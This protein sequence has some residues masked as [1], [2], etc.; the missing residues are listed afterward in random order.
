MEVNVDDAESRLSSLIVQVE[1]T[2]EEIVIH[3]DNVPVAKLVPRRAVMPQRRLG[4]WAKVIVS[5]DVG[6]LPQDLAGAFAGDQ[7]SSAPRP[8][9]DPTVVLIERGDEDHFSTGEAWD[10]E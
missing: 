9:V 2:G 4:G 3:R 7:T 1:R 5:D 10:A 8:P 6:E